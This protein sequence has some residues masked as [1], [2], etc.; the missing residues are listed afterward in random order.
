V[1]AIDFLDVGSEELPA[2]VILFDVNVQTIATITSSGLGT[3]SRETLD[4]G[5]ICGV[6]V[7]MIDFYA[8]GG[9]DN[10]VVCVDPTGGPETCGNGL[11]DDGDG[12]VDEGCPDGDDDD[13]DTGEVGDDDDDNSGSCYDD[14][15]NGD[16]DECENPEG[17]N[18]G[19]GSLLPLM[20]P[21]PLL[22]R[23]RRR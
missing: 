15:E 3:N 16:D 22:M 18:P 17:C 19:G 11:D 1:H 23:R 9:W 4:L 7:M 8:R 20:L 12:F 5:G 14:N 10:L 13:D 2:Q 21:L 6:F